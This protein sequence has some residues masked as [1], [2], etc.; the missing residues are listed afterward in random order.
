L[1]SATNA[2]L[3]RLIAEGRFREDLLFRINVVEIHVPPLRERRADIVPLAFAALT[4]AAQ[5]Y[6]RSLRAFSP[7]ALRALQQYAWPGNI[8]ELQHVIERAVLL[9]TG[10]QIEQ[11]DLHLERAT[12]VPP[13]LEE[14]SLDDADRMLIHSALKRSDGSASAAA[15]ALG[16]S[17]SAIYRRMEKLGIHAD[18]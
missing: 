3:P 6:R 7:E 11:D 16:L 17:R 14:M 12:S 9:A 5:R 4:A 18:E 8:R 10:D 15:A 13:S 1:I 2:I